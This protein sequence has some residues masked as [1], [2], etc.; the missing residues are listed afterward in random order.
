MALRTPAL[1]GHGMD[2]DDHCRSDPARLA[3]MAARPDAMVLAMDGLMPVIADNRLTFTPLAEAGAGEQVYLGL[4]DGVPLFAPVPDAGDTRQAYQQGANRALIMALAPRDLAIYA[5]ARSLVDWHARHRFCANCGA[6]T[7]L[8]KG[9]WQRNCSNTETCGAAHFP[10]TDPV[11]IM[12][13]EHE[14]SVLLG[15]GAHWAER[16]YSA[17][18]GFVEPGESIEE[19]VA[20]ETFEE[21]GVRVR[22]IS[23]VASQPWPFPSNLMIGCHGY[24][25][26]PA[27][28]LDPTELADARWFTRAECVEAIANGS[29]SQSFL[30]PPREAIARTLIEWWLEK[31]E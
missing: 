29:D 14:G 23:Y 16:V 2:R 9:G 3:A 4:K 12:L 18:A 20:R 26:D 8:A 31:T 24:A 1:T 7:Q 11:A 6:P 17:L 13:I 21:A 5:G 22:D 15:R 28:Q 25:D 10:R 27:I 19:A 30:P